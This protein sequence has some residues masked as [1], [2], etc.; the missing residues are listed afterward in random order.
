MRTSID[1]I[2]VVRSGGELLAPAL[3]GLLAQ[4]RAPERLLI[5]NTSADS[6]LPV[7]IDSVLQ[8]G[9]LA[10][11]TLILP[12]ATPFAEAIDEALAHLYGPGA[13]PPHAS[14]LWLL[15]D[16][17]VARDTTLEHLALTVEAAPLIKVAG[18]KQRIADRPGVLRELGETMTR[19]GE[20]FALAERERD[21]AQY[22]RMSDVL[23]VGEAGMLI[24]AETLVSVGGFDEVLSARDG[25]LDVCVRVRLRGHRIVVVP[26]AIVEVGSGVADWN[27]RKTL[28]SSRQYFLAQRA[29]SYRRLVY[30]P[31][32]A[33]LPLLVV[34]LPWSLIRAVGHLVAKRPDRMVSEVFAA[35]WSL[36]HLG[37]VVRARS[38][39]AASRTTSWAA[40]DALRMEPGEVRR[41]RG[42]SRET[43]RA[44]AEEKA[45]S[46]PAPRTLPALPWLLL[47]LTVIAA[48]L[49][50]PWWGAG[51]LVGG[52]ALP[53]GESFA[54]MW[55]QAWSFVPTQWGFGAEAL[56][57]D[58]ALLVF[59]ALGSLTWWN[60]GLAL[61]SLLIAAVPIA[62]AFAWWGFS[63]V[64]SKA[65]VVAVVA[66][67]WA[68]SP[69]L[70]LSV[71][72]GRVGAVIAHLTLP[73]LVGALLTAHESWQRVGGAAL[74]TIVVTA[75]APVLWPAV[76]LGVVVVSLVRLRT[77][78]VRMFAGVVPLVVLPALVLATPRA[79]AWFET[80]QGRWWESLGVAFADPGVSPPY[81][82]AS[83]WE[84]ALGWPSS[85]ADF[86]ESLGGSALS[87]VPLI[88]VLG[89]AILVAVAASSF[90]VGRPLVGATSAVLFSAGLLTATMSPVLFSGYDGGDAVF[91][92][93]GTGVSLVVLGVLIGAGA[94]LDRVDFQDVL[95][96]P[97]QGG[98]QWLARGVTAIVAV[99]ALVTP[100]AIAYQVWTHQTLVNP[101]TEPRTLPAFVAAEAL[102]TPGVGTLVIESFPSGYQVSLKRGSGDTLS[103]TSTLVRGRSSEVT[104][105]DEDLARLAAMLVRP[106]SADPSE[107]LQA[108]GIRFVL[109][110]GV[111]DSEAALS[112]SRQVG[113]V[114]ASSSEA[115]QLWQV[116]GVSVEDGVSESPPRGGWGD[117]FLILLAI[118]SV[119]GVPTQRLARASTERVDDAVPMLGEETSDDV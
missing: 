105:R 33:L 17:V 97:L 43:E 113:L 60:P 92:W 89:A 102:E 80:T 27:A 2:L 96:N 72:E 44:L 104:P 117:L 15:R 54:G 52:G 6:T 39:L 81:A 12:Y 110:S 99:A 45:H 86:G 19:F 3:E 40:I 87:L 111:E 100:S 37:P 98:A 68:L 62:G 16:D 112:L 101:V 50:G 13:I 31:W 47:G 42:V 106:S 10:S 57:S 35:L 69:T 66:A 14:W 90:V 30:A 34:A 82:T 63:Q 21:Q 46:I 78:A 64:L 88:A 11:E 108:Y 94:T 20:R 9:A 49:F 28:S 61:V 7:Q 84:V 103:S 41:R 22:D 29:W 55:G 116:P 85:T 56:P 91:V 71:S 36:G 83:W 8:G 115:L 51:A 93:P 76:V 77:H 24:H 26:R 70:L 48:A 107:I 59:A 18:P 114:R 4:T 38:T 67:L 23:A 95:G 65:W 73:L 109:L 53:L 1:A 119:L 58:P 25:G 79:M 75:T 32:W 118:V 5:I 74:A